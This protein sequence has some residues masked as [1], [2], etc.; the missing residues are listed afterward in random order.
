MLCAKRRRGCG[1]SGWRRKRATTR[2]SSPRSLSAQKQLKKL[3]AFVRKQIK[4]ISAARAPHFFKRL[5]SVSTFPIPPAPTPPSSTWER[6]I[7]TWV[8][9]R[10]TTKVTRF[11]TSPSPARSRGSAD[12]R[13]VPSSTPYRA[14]KHRNKPLAFAASNDR[15]IFDTQSRARAKGAA[16]AS[17]LEVGNAWPSAIGRS[18]VTQRFSMRLR[19]S[20][21]GDRLQPAAHVSLCVTDNL[22][23]TILCH[24]LSVTA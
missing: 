21:A 8:R 3:R 17:A 19:H 4:L 13:R 12:L 23:G 18:A 14:L 10:P 1:L 9:W 11:L 6:P 22:I 5:N 15:S 24:H 20:P 7:A 2:L 16:S